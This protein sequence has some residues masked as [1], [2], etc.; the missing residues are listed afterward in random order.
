MIR[1]AASEGT[2]CDTAT[3][4]TPRYHNVIDP[5]TNY[6][7]AGSGLHSAD[8]ITVSGSDHAAPALYNLGVFGGGEGNTLLTT[9]AARRF[10][11]MWA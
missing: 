7:S 4:P 2:H 1:F 10:T 11:A 8:D 9:T 3:C 6:V 5:L